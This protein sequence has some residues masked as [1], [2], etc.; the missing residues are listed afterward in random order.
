VKVGTEG[1]APTSARLSP[2]QYDRQIDSV[3]EVV[4]RVVPSNATVLVVSRGDD[5]L[6]ELGPRR[7]LHFPQSDE[8]AYAG[9][10]PA[11]SDEAIVLLENMRARGAEFLVLPSVAFWWLDYYDAFKQYVE[12]RY[13][14]VEAGQ[15]C[16]IAALTESSGAGVD[17]GSMSRPSTSPPAAELGE[18]LDSLL[19]EDARTAILTTSEQQFA[20]VYGYETWLVPHK[21]S[22]SPEGVGGVVTRLEENGIR[23][24]VVPKALFGWLEAH[25]DLADLL[26]GHHRLVT[27]QAHLCE[28]YELRHR[29]QPLVA[30]PV[31]AAPAAGTGKGNGRAR[32]FGE[33]LRGVLFRAR[34]NDRS[35]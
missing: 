19:P 12:H 26:Q 34:R 29:A 22:E 30:Q 6:L 16:W 8:G 11:D 5:H 23:F 24:V 33:S 1:E 32:S 3:R 13:R 25:P 28:V 17:K 9:Y 14:L 10:H 21:L 27:R 2:G 31:P 15:H 4:H 20:G 35:S 7:A 18:L